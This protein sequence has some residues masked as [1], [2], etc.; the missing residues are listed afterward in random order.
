MGHSSLKI[1]DNDV[2]V[3]DNY[4]EEETHSLKEGKVWDNNKLDN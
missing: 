3:K 2:R 1:K 4:L